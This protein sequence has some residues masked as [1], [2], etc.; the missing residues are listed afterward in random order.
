M[1]LLSI[2]IFFAIGNRLQAAQDPYIFSSECIHAYQLI[3][4]LRF[5]AATV[6]LEKEKINHPENV[7]PVYL[8]HYCLFLKSFISENESAFTKL[9]E[10]HDYAIRI[11]ERTN[12]SSPYARYCKADVNIL[13]AFSKIKFKEYISAALEIRR[14]FKLLE[15]N[16]RL[17]PSFAPTLKSLGLLHAFIGAV[18]ENYKWLLKFVGLT[19]TIKEGIDELATA[20]NDANDATSNHH[21][22]KSET[23]CLYLFT[24]HHLE[25]NYP[26]VLPLLTEF[27]LVKN[28]VE[29]FFVCNLLYNSGKNDEVLNH[30]LTHKR[31]S[32][33][34]P[35]YYLDFLL[36]MTKL[37]RLDFSAYSHFND[38]VQLYKG[39][40]F[41]K[42][43][44]QK[45]AWIGLLKGDTMAY[46]NNIKMCGVK[47][48]D[49]TDEDKQAFNEFNTKSFPN[50]LLLRSRLLFD[51][52]YYKN[53]LLELAGKDIHYF[54]TV[55]DQLEL[56]YRLARIY[57]KMEND[58]N[59][60]ELYKKTIQNG[61]SYT[62]YFAANSS[63]HLGNLFEKRRD[64]LNAEK[65]YRMC[66]AMR[67]HEYQNSI[68]QKAKAGL[69]RLGK[70]ER[71]E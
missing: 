49:F 31:E 12:M 20:F 32:D 54:P 15:E 6:I 65:Y 51:G 3:F 41:V 14:A 9:K 62:Y 36:G 68:D 59:A 21:F 71:N 53:A 4:D 10:H 25:Q 16:K 61:S 39:N 43:A 40:S 7:I 11:F 34:Y 48:N 28:P 13:T 18:P 45:L 60:I 47:G 17:Y 70:T 1:R 27:S 69:N 30:L 64:T 8:E 23:L 66:L 2:I 50:A 58:S 5:D 52:G 33:Q 67:N 42:A 19:G 24:R 35:F 38:Y 63:L 46:L 57:D 56:T 29:L 22:L 44:W 26:N 37:N 55:K